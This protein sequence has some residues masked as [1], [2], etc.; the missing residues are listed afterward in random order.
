MR[1][2]R[3][4]TVIIVATISGIVIHSCCEGY[5]Y[6]FTY[7][8]TKNIA[9]NKANGRL[10]EIFDTVSVE[11]YGIR[12]YL[13]EKKY[14]CNIPNPFM[15]DL[16][17]YDCWPIFEMEDSIMEIN[18]ITVNKFNALKDRGDDVTT[19]F[20]VPYFSFQEGIPVNEKVAQINRD[21]R[22][23]VEYI[24]LVLYDASARD[25]I[26]QF[27]INVLLS[28]NTTLTDTTDAIKFTR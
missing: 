26:Q 1:I 13:F 19:S 25:S 10:T 18:V 3:I 28:D 5:H 24:D 9:L 6:K 22:S 27:V 4:L 16:Y 17:A 2:F 20:Q 15:G 11:N 14:A 12:V 8:F 7:I 23:V 21:E